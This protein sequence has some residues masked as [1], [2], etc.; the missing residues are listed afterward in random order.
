MPE[1]AEADTWARIL[2]WVGAARIVEGGWGSVFGFSAIGGYWRNKFRGPF[3]RSVTRCRTRTLASIYL[4]STNRRGFGKGI[5][6]SWGK[7]IAVTGFDFSNRWRRFWILRCRQFD[8][9]VLPDLVSEFG[10]IA[11]IFQ[12]GTQRDIPD[13]HFT[14][15]PPLICRIRTSDN[16][17]ES[18]MLHPGFL[19]ELV[20]SGD[21]F[22]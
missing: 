18:V 1:L 13:S 8:D 20:D 21:P 14:L 7:G 9:A 22:W 3:A 5:R 4:D 16:Q 2:N 15:E 11:E 17:S 12:G 6:S 10:G 19:D